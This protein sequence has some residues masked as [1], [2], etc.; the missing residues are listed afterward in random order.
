VLRRKKCWTASGGVPFEGQVPGQVEVACHQVPRSSRG[1]TAFFRVLWPRCVASH[2]LNAPSSSLVPHK[3][4]D[5]EVFR[6]AA[7]R[8]T[9]AYRESSREVPFSFRVLPA[10]TVARRLVWATPSMGFPVPTA[11]LVLGVHY[12]GFASPGTFRFQVFSTS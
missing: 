5:P 4:L 6:F 10:Y 11:S 12:P 9:K 2:R 3:G 1:V 7:F 8:K